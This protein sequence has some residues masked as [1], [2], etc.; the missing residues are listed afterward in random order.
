MIKFSLTTNE[1]DG[2]KLSTSAEGEVEVEIVKQLT[3]LLIEKIEKIKVTIG[4]D[5]AEEE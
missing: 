3:Q 4:Y 5:E 2:F 1:H